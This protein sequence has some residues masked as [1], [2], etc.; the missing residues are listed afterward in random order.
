MIPN[1]P[2]SGN[3]YRAGPSR[4]SVKQ[5]VVAHR[6]VEIGLKL[7]ARATQATEPDA[8]CETKNAAVTQGA[9]LAATIGEALH[10]D[11]LG[12]FWKYRVGHWRIVASIK[13]AVLTI[14]VIEIDHGSTIYR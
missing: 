1:M 12:S 8:W 6:C 2:G 3:A 14:V 11:K 5:I 7:R 10:G 9:R 13:D 4:S